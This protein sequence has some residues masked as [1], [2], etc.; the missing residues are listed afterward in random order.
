MKYKLLSLF[1]AVLAFVF[2]GNAAF[3]LGAQD[4]SLKNARKVLGNDNNGNNGNI[5]QPEQKNQNTSPAQNTSQQAGNNSSNKITATSV[6]N[7]VLGG[8]AG[9]AGNLSF[10]NQDA[11]DALKNA[12]NIGA[13]TASKELNKTDAYYRNP[14]YY[15]PMPPEAAKLVST[16]EKLPN[17]KKTV[18]NVIIRLNRTAEACAAGIVPIFVEAISGM[19]VSDGISIVTGEQ[20]A[21]TNFLKDKTYNQLKALYK[22]QIAAALD[23]NLVGSMSANDAWDKLV[24]LYNKT[25]N[26]ANKIGSIFGKDEVME[27]I[28][29]DLAEYATNKALDAIFL[30]IADEEKSIRRN[31]MEYGSSIIQKVFGAVKNQ[32]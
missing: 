24:S 25:G 20:N 19:S 11:V 13:E 18:E 3:A 14:L 4:T 28:D 32:N 27:T 8:V 29:T 6:I 26:S 9:N 31:P 12:L 21:A 15:I 2:A 16:V 7:T 23:Q 10:S 30:K 1:F 17:G 5:E 22:P